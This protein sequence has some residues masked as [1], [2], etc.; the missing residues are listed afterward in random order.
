MA[1]S[2]GAV[3]YLVDLVRGDPRYVDAYQNLYSAYSL[4]ASGA[5]FGFVESAVIK[6]MNDFDLDLVDK[7]LSERNESFI[8]LMDQLY[9]AGG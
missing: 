7:I 1:G 5:P 3:A 8:D 2:L 9:P 4:L 6:A